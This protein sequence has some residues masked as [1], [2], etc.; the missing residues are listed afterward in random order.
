MPLLEAPGALV[1]AIQ[2]FVAGRPPSDID[3]ERWRTLL[4]DGA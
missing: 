3:P 1:E 4:R 2:R